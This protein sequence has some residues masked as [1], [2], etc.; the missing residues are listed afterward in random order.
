MLPSGAGPPPRQHRSRPLPLPRVLRRAAP[1]HL[2]A[3]P[4]AVAAPVQAYME[5]ELQQKLDILWSFIKTHLKAGG[6]ARPRT[7]S[8]CRYWKGGDASA[9]QLLWTAGFASSPHPKTHPT[10]S[11]T[12]S[13]TL[14]FQPPPPPTPHPTPFTHIHS[15]TTTTHMPPHGRQ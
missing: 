1:M 7:L 14:T 2:T 6:A 9:G 8:W 12:P 15:N 3:G 4:P 11:P 10:P 13:A 5:C